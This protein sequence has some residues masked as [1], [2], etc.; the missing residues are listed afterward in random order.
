MIPFI[1]CIGDDPLTERY[2]SCMLEIAKAQGWTTFRLQAVAFEGALSF[3]RGAAEGSITALRDALD[4]LRNAPFRLAMSWLVAALAEGLTGTGL[5][6]EAIT[7][8][9]GEIARINRDGD[10]VYL[11]NILRVK[12]DILSS[13]PEPDVPAAED[14]LLRSLELAR[15]QTALS[16]ELR[17]AMSL[18]RLRRE[19]GRGQDGRNVLATVYG[20]FT[21][22]FGSYDLVAAKRLLDELT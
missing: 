20:R 17:A 14:C 6:Y 11:P 4:A 2:T 9:D 5:H 7:L 21:E 15:R 8:I 16:W 10:L 1:F 13:M 19:Q 18:A 22:G 12:A 3:R